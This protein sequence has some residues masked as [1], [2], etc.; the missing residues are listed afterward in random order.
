MRGYTAFG[1]ESFKA[2]GHMLMTSTLRTD[3]CRRRSDGLRLPAVQLRG[4]TRSRWPPR[5]SRRCPRY[6]PQANRPKI[7]GRRESSAAARVLGVST[8][9]DA[10]EV[11]RGMKFTSLTGHRGLLDL[12]RYRNRS[13]CTAGSTAQLGA[14]RFD[15]PSNS[16]QTACR[17]PRR[18]DRLGLIGLWSLKHIACHNDSGST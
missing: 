10:N 3:S 2:L 5:M 1:R 9:V 14:L 17:I 6:V 16:L 4:K 8:H 18:L 7:V 12:P 15:S 13:V 11:T